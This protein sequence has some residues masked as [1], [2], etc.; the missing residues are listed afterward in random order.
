M[1]PDWIIHYILCERP[2]SH[3]H[4]LDRYGSLELELNLPVSQ[5]K[6]CMILNL[7]GNEIAEKGKRYHSGDREDAVFTLPC[8]LLET[9]PATPDSQFTRVLRVLIC[10]PKGKYPWEPGC[11]YG[12]AQQLND[13][14]KYEMRKLCR[15][16]SNI[17]PS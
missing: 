16:H 11:E 12:Y 17:L 6:A 1:K 7:M 4:G 15:M 5:E 13:R 9:T 8:Y 10:D 3:T 14:E 2:S